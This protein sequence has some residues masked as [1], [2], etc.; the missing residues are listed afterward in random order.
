MQLNTVV[1]QCN[2][3]TSYFAQKTNH[4]HSE[5]GCISD[6]IGHGQDL[7]GGG[8]GVRLPLPFCALLKLLVMMTHEDLD[9][10]GP[11]Y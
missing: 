9:R 2:Q 10:Q 1:T 3:F 4:I 6:C 11:K 8:G 5:L 7:G